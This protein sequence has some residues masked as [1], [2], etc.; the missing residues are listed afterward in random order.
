MAM[1]VRRAICPRLSRSSV[2]ERVV[3]EQCELHQRRMTCVESVARRWRGDWRYDGVIH[4]KE[5]TKCICVVKIIKCLVDNIV[6]DISFNQVGGLCTL[7]FLDEV[8]ILIRKNHLF[9]RSIILIKAWC[10]YESRILG[11]HHGLISTYALETLVLYI[12]HVFNNC[13]TGPLEL[14]YHFLEF[15]SNFDWERFCLSLWGPVP[16]SSLPDMSAEPPRL[17]GGD[18]LLSKPFLDKCSYSYAVTP[19]IQEIQYQQSFVSKH[20]NVIDPLRINNNLGRSISKGNFFRIRSA[21]SF[22]ARRLEKLL[23]CPK[24]DLIAEVN[25]F[26]TNTWIRHGSGNRP[27]APTPNLVPQHALKVVPAEASNSQRSAMLFKKKAENPNLQANQDNLTEGAH[28]YPPEVTSQLLQRG[29]LHFRNSC[30]TVNPVVSHSHHQKIHATHANTKVSEQLERN[31]SDGSMQNERDKGMPNS[32]SVNDRNGQNR[33]R[34]ART[35]SS[36]ELT[37]PSI[38]GYYRGR[39]IRVFEMEKSLK[40][41]YNSRRNNLAPEVSSSH[42]TKSSQDESMSLM[43]SSSFYSMSAASDSHS[44]SSSYHEDNGFVMNDD[45]S[46]VSEASEKEQ[47]EQVLV[48]LMASAKLHEFNGQVQLP[49]QMSSNLS[50]TPSPLHA[51]TAYSQKHFGGVPPTSLIGVPWPN[52]QLLHGFVQP[53]MTHYMHSHAFASSIEDGNESEK[54]ISD[55]SRDD[56]NNWHEYGVRLSRFF[57]HQ[58]R[59]PQVHH[60]NGKEHSASPNIVSGTP[61][62]RQVEIAIEDCW[63]VE[64]KYTNMFQ[65]QISRQVSINAAV[66]SGNPRIP[67]SQASLLRNK[68]PPENSWDELAGKTSGSLR[69][70]WG[71]KPDFAAP[72]TTTHSKNNTGWQTGNA[73]EHI[74]PEADGP[75]NG[76]AIP[77][78]RNEASD[79]TTR[80]DSTTPRASQIPNDF[81]PSQMGMPNPMFAPFIIRSPQHRQADS[82]KLTFIPTGPSDS[83]NLTFVP[84]SPPDSSK[85]TFVQT[86]PPVPFVMLPFVPGNGDGSVPQFERNEGVDSHPINIAVQNFGSLND[87]QHPDTNATPM[88][89]T[90]TVD[91]PSDEQRPDILNSDFGSHWHN[92]QYGRLCQNPRHMDPMFPF[93]VPP[94]YLHGHVLMFHG[95]G[96][97]D[98]LQQ[99]LTG[100]RLGLLAN[101]SFL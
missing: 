97:V 21:F 49:M 22:G 96:L 41:D 81:E 54:S 36:P 40:A 20:F 87:V 23:E 99:M 31:R 4:D 8:D 83:S 37:D 69:D 100:H 94:M 11:A 38:E 15:F 50:V 76:V 27:D 39:W 66:S 6:V 17:D 70:K 44:V 42:I 59:D 60:F 68:A 2:C 61:L 26:F 65:N 72:A 51:P 14:L 47:E 77:N 52:M 101:E 78:I 89:S 34:F 1:A 98:Q 32:L 24:E 29:D 3:A 35:R 45:L 33:S 91:D 10:F 67:S 13:F 16:I 88:A 25:M 63:G 90:S 84:T 7:C 12:F 30:R 80:S 58:G 64:E 55:A 57:N 53:P 62:E 93:A 75:R 82:S 43:N 9:K 48:N 95:M 5:T 74:P 56:G 18:L 79:V 46:S 19:H 85:L 92:L 28:S 73:T 86:G 71:E